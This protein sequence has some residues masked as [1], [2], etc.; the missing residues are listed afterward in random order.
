M[1]QIY[2]RNTQ[3]DNER[4]EFSRR[5]ACGEAWVK[6]RA[7]LTSAEDKTNLSALRSGHFSL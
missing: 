7:L 3:K 1:C 6:H 2:V 5:V 4:G